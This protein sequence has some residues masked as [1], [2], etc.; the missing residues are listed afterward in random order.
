MGSRLKLSL[1]CTSFLITIL[2]VVGAVLGKSEQKEG[3]GAY[4]PLAVYTEILARIKSDYVEEPDIPK[5]TQ[6]ALQGL[7]EYLDPLSSYLSPEQFAE[8]KERQGHPDGGSGLSTG[9]VVH[10][11][12]NYTSV[13]AV[14]P[15]SP[16]D[17][18]GIRGD[19]LLDA[20]NDVSTRVMPPAYLRAM[21]SG[22]PGTSVDVMVRSSSDYDS[23]VKHTLVRAEPLLPDVESRMLDDGIGY[24]DV[25]FLGPDQVRQVA[26]A[27]GSL[28]AEGA[29]K[30]VL[31]LRGNALGTAEDG[32]ALAD[33]VLDAG[34][35][36]TLKGKN[37]ADKQFAAS[38]ETTVTSLP[39]AVIVN[40]PTAG[41]AEIAAAAIQQ[42]DRGEV[43]GESSAGLAAVQETV[44]LDDGAAL[45]LSVAKFYGPGGE[46]IH[47][48]GVEPDRPVSQ[49]DLRRYREVRQREYDTPEAQ[50][51]AQEEVGDPFLDM[52][53]EALNGSA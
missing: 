26:D 10:K 17:K 21:L 44:S 5:V 31:D 25:D 38:A 34:P 1:V 14:L 29:E 50:E 33:L 27:V 42:N 36:G 18:A 40:R 48:E 28:K 16:A 45:I 15:G 23:P 6:G 30:L 8:Y 37:Y 49:R 52:A 43:V 3:S 12:G 46:A 20:I 7:V 47:K 13:L 19:D 24:L 39:L 22:E 53:L 35:I 9:L 41:G 2:L 32:I 51:E 11:Q 4:R